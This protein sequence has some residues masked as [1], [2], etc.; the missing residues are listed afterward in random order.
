MAAANSP[1]WWHEFYQEFR[2]VFG[3]LPAKSATTLV[4]RI[5]NELGLSKGSTLLDCPCGY[6]RI[7]IPL[8]RKGIRVTGV[9]IMP[10]YLKELE[11]R[12]RRAKLK[13]PTVHSD[14]R[15]INFENH[16]DAAANIWTSFGYFEKESDNLLVLKKYYKDR[17]RIRLQPA[18]RA[19]KPIFVKNA[20][21]F[22]V[23]VGVVRKVA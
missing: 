2:P 1:E 3:I 4:R 19:M 23:V 16:F 15:R 13:I 12:A 21:V 5:I 9:D 20:K 17:G 8:A 14:M 7:S 22:G 11:K 6:G 18:N 10:P